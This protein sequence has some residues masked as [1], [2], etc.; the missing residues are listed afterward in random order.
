MRHHY[1]VGVFDDPSKARQAVDDAVAAGV[2]R[3][4]ILM[5]MPSSDPLGDPQNSLA[6]LAMHPED[7][8]E[9]SQ[10]GGG[11]GGAVGGFLGAFSLYL[12]DAA[13]G[14]LYIGLC[15][16]IL[17]GSAA[18]AY[19][20]HISPVLL[21]N[22]KDS[23]F[24]RMIQRDN[25]LDDRRS[26][27]GGAIGGAFGSLAGTIS[28]Y[29]IGIPSIWFFVSTGLWAATASI[30]FGSLVGAM[31]G[32]GLAPK[33]LIGMEDLVE[34]EQEILVSIDCADQGEKVP[35]IEAL[36]RRDGA[37]AIRPS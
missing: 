29:L 26:I 36:L 7:A 31:S 30:V 27:L 12:G 37:R 20:A 4:R 32:R 8:T 9:R 35:E 34:G 10:V 6:D 17:A 3:R 21:K 13:S 2:S 25:Q 33:Q 28:S 14:A 16:S 18:G 15:V 1:R 11:L 5:V 23:A 24:G 19:I 22:I